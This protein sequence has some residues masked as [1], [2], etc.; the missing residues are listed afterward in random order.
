MN[1]VA[2]TTA[3]LVRHGRT[4]LNAAGVLRGHVNIPLD[5]VGQ[6]EA[7][8]LGELFAPVRLA[9]VISSPLR[10]A[11]QTAAPIAAAVGVVTQVDQAFVDR[12]YGQWSGVSVDELV[13]RFGA[14]GAAPGV[15]PVAAFERRVRDRWEA[16]AAE[17]KGEAYVVVTHDAVCRCLVGGALGGPG[18]PGPA[19]SQRTGC[20]NRLELRGGRWHAVI[21]DALAGD[22]RRPGATPPPHA[23]ETRD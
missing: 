17:L 5:A 10:R 13:A 3:Y 4:T 11:L 23:T 20:W 21:V 12:D 8:R 15:E 18:T 2:S 16:V 19:I 9:A 22:G 7:A 1:A 14:L 6:V